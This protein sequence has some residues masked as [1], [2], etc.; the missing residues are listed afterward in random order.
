MIMQVR[1]D[2]MVLLGRNALERALRQYRVSVQIRRTVRQPN[3]IRSG[4]LEQV[5]KGE[6]RGGISPPR[7]PRTVGELS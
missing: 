1:K 2:G 7:S 3:D 5:P 6:W 4:V